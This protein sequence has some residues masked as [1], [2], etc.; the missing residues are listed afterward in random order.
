MD[1]YNFVRNLRRDLNKR[2]LRTILFAMRTTLCAV[3][4]KF[5]RSVVRMVR[6]FKSQR[7]CAQNSTQTFSVCLRF[8]GAC[9]YNLQ[10]EVFGSFAFESLNL[11]MKGIMV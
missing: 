6:L 1:A 4:Y 7:N 10:I 11:R 8:K 2:I 9:P 5:V 3:T